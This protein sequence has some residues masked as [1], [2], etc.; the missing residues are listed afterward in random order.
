VN[1]IDNKAEKPIL[2]FS[3]LQ[4]WKNKIKLNDKTYLLANIH[5][6][7]DNE[8]YSI[9]VSKKLLTEI[10]RNLRKRSFLTKP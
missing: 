8:N 10:L 3:I 7:N 9:V 4:I 2:P 5:K 1:K 6:N